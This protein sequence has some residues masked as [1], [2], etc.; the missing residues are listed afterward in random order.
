[1]KSG[2]PV[3]SAVEAGTRTVAGAALVVIPL[4][5]L[6]VLAVAQTR[7]A[8]VAATGVLLI[9]LTVRRL[10][11]LPVLAM[12]ALAVVVRVGPEQV[13]LSLSDLAL[14]AGFGIAVLFAPRPYTPALRALLWLSVIYQVA[15]LFTVLA[16]PYTANTVEWFHA[17]MSVA[18]ALIFG[19][20]V[21]RSGMAGAGLGLLLLALVAIAAL[22]CGQ[23]VVQ[24]L[25][26]DTGPVYLDWPYGMHKNFIGT[27][28]A[29]GALLAYAR[30][31]WLGW[32]SRWALA[33]FWLC[34]LGVLA[35]QA[36]Q[37][38]VGLGIGIVILVL[39][40]TSRRHSR[41]ILL[42]VIPAAWFVYT[43]V[44]D[45]LTSSNQFNSTQQR[46]SWYADSLEVWRM[47]EWFGVGLRWWVAGRTEFGF[48]PP[49]AELEVVSSA[50]A[51]GLL[52]FLILMVGALVVLWRVDPR[53]GT[54]AFAMLAMR[55]VQGQLD[56]FWVAVQV[57]V[58]FVIVGTCLGAQAY[59]AA[60]DGEAADAA[61]AARK[62][63][64]RPGRHVAVP[65]LAPRASVPHTPAPALLAPAMIGH[66]PDP[67]ETAVAR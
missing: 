17:W 25:A 66:G 21:G 50:G 27:A 67:S 22:T 11:A 18:G 58:P 26:G 31:G 34:T 29:F 65:A 51:V 6:G 35:S 14:S 15:T 48:Q 8:L 47:N 19:W 46:L 40:R 28:L 20:A 52:G 49:N 24:L 37:A 60:S 62:S 64:S 57:S 32:S 44:R 61:E 55:L 39:R 5:V 43:T 13:D 33:A 30:P 9:G 7:Y 36:R 3:R 41:M 2:L 16:N 23:S 63:T 42:A 12:P 38:L 53:F 10:E 45:Q 1:V 56:L 54:L 59:A 4:S